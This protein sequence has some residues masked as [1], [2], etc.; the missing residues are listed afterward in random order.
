MNPGKP[1][2]ASVILFEPP[3][4][5]LWRVVGDISEAEMLRLRVVARALSAG[6]PYVL[7]L[8]DLSRIGAVSAGARKASID[9]EP[10]APLLG[11]A[12]FGASFT[13]RVIAQFVNTAA[14]LL[15]R[16]KDRTEDSRIHFFATEEPARAWL[17]DRREA[18]L[19]KI[20]T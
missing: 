2:G 13:T 7:S 16:P 5:L 18:A 19:L 15:A 10:V 9:P 20:R 8:V 17:A 1:N 11:T 3:D 14:S 4:I 6:R 12:I